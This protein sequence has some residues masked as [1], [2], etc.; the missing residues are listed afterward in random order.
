MSGVIGYVG[1]KAAKPFLLQGL[2]KLEYRGYDSAGICE[3]DDQLNVYKTKGRLSEL[4]KIVEDKDLKGTIGIG[5]TA[6]VTHGAPTTENAEPQLSSDGS[7]AVV[8]DGII[9]N[10]QQ[11]K[12][13]LL[14]AGYSFTSESA[15]EVI[16]HLIENN[17][18]ADLL[19]AVQAT[20][21]VLQ[22]SY[23]ILVLSAK[24]PQEIVAAKSESPLVIGIGSNENYCA[25]D[26]QALLDYTREVYILQDGECARITKDHIEL[27][28]QAGFIKDLQTEYIE[29]DQVQ[30]EKDGYE[31]FMLKEIHEQPKGVRETIANRLDSSGQLNLAEEIPPELV[32]GINK[33]Q[34]IACGTAY[35]AC[36][37]GKYLLEQFLDI[38]VEAEYA[39][40]YRYNRV[41]AD[42]NTLLIVLS[43]SGETADTL[44]AMRVAQDKGARVLAVTNVI[45]STLAREADAVMLTH[46]GPEI[47]VASTK[48]YTAQ[49][50]CLCLIAIYISQ[51]LNG[52][53]DQELLTGLRM[54]PEQIQKV[55]HDCEPIVQEYANR[56]ATATDAFFLGRGIDYLSAMEGQLKLKETSYIHGEA[57]P[58]GELKHGTMALIAPGVQVV[59]LATQKV[60]LDKIIS[61]LQEVKARGGE[62]L[63]I[64]MDQDFDYSNAGNQ[65]IFIP[66]V[67]P[68][69][70]PMLSVVPMQLLAYYTTKAKGLDVDK[71]RNL[72]KSVTV[73]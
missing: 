1:N 63:I 44:G 33:I 47:A 35:H 14:E 32:K 40:E 60:L 45:S 72:V 21:K 46:A 64:A 50:A 4:N 2:N 66:E 11:L 51:Q 16:A 12:S 57:L 38:P 22:G 31:H 59:G 13:Q 41:K 23:A 69:L 8:S 19:Q 34:F 25:S 49:L 62:I 26:V 53:V 36:L 17:Y 48:A 15:A 28:D 3:F 65:T 39:S 9:E 56:Y 37:Y 68:L 27:F 6:W 43:Q 73:E 20:V 5:H 71:P 55:L 67:H 54:I 42:Q 58:G 10:A 24:H 29:W 70:A 7:I 61:N 30:V 18:Q 52:V